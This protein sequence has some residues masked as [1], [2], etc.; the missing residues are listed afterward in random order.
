MVTIRRNCFKQTLNKYKTFTVV[1]GLIILFSSSIANA[2]ISP[3]RGKAIQGGLITFAADNASNIELDGEAMTINQKNGFVVGFHRDDVEL[4]TITASCLNGSKFRLELVPEKRIYK[5]QEIN[6]LPSNMVTPPKR[7]LN[8]IANDSKMVKQARSIKGAS[9]DYFISGFDW[10]VDGVITGVYGSQR[11]LNGKP[12]QPHFG[13]DIA[14]PTGTLITASAAGTV[15]MAKDLYF[16]GW[17]VIIAHGDYISSTYSHLQKISVEKGEYIKRGEEIGQVGSTGRSTG[18]H[19]DWRIN[20]LNKRLDPQ[21]IAN[22][23][24]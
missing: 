6:G 13:I 10:P 24:H 8:R 3:I 17:T 14:A 22:K 1:S 4:I 19:L 9:A 21:L 23:N 16:T 18:A 2:C 5:I 15:V 11:I 20:W 7:V 12:R